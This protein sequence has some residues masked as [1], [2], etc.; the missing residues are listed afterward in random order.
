MQVAPSDANVDVLFVTFV[1]TKQNR[2]DFFYGPVGQLPGNYFWE[3]AS[4]G[5]SNHKTS[6]QFLIFYINIL[7]L[8]SFIFVLLELNLLN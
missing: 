8:L 5:S 6:Q 3:S 1:I 2:I 7:I 4:S